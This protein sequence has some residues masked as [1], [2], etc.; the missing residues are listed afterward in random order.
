M[1]T[2]LIIS[3]SPLLPGVAGGMFCVAISL[4]S[5]FV[6]SLIQ[7]AYLSFLY[8]V[9]HW[10]H[11]GNEATAPVRRKCNIAMKKVIKL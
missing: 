10:R 9:G 5:P 6:V 1:V 4:H 3:L 2:V 7:C 8:V 11:Q